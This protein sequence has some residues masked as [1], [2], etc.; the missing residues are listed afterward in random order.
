[1]AVLWRH[2]IHPWYMQGVQQI[3]DWYVVERIIFKTLGMILGMACI[4][5][6]NVVEE[7]K[8]WRDFQ[9]FQ[10]PYIMVLTIGGPKDIAMRINAADLT[11]RAY[12]VKKRWSW[13]W[14][15]RN[16]LSLPNYFDIKANK[17][18]TDR[19]TKRQTFFW[20]VCFWSKI[21]ALMKKKTICISQKINYCEFSTSCK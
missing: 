7:K 19:P 16:D 8:S 15:G 11:G 14:E 6:I 18:A 4:S 12:D 10:S 5:T 3:F 17:S 2:V 13:I 1:M 20:V 21:I 9:V